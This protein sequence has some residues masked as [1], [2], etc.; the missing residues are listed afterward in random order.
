MEPKRVKDL[1]SSLIREIPFF[2]NDR[3][4]KEGLHDQALLPIILHHLHWKSRFIPKR[5]RAVFIEG[6]AV[7]DKRVPELK[8]K[9]EALLSDVK[10]G[11][12]LS[13]YLSSKADNKGYT[14]HTDSDKWADKDFLLNVTGF[15]HLHLNKSP[16]RSNEVIFARVTRE[17]FHVIAI[18]DHSA[19]ESDATDDLSLSEERSR[20]FAI[21][22]EYSSRGLPPN[23]VYLP[24]IITTSG[25]PLEIVDIAS[26]YNEIVLSMD[27]KLDD[28][29]FI[30]SIY[31]EANLD[32][33]KN[34][35]LKWYIHD[36]DLGIL[37][38]N[39]NFFVLKYGPC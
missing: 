17:E 20:I 8:E 36:L 25:H 18:S 14:P 26:S 1:K 31:E 37:D 6:Y 5:P 16:E 11:N 4:T 15:H 23:S 10:G 27:K 34:N 2:P 22:R 29:D 3:A 7:N 38:K 35:K 13:P 24:K 12:D 21:F 39:R 32:R 33:P 9:I 30:N 19:F 28:N